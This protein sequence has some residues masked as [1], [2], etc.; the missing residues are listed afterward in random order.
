[1]S[2]ENFASLIGEHG[3]ND[4]VKKYRIGPS[5]MSCDEKNESDTTLP[6]HPTKSS[7]HQPNVWPTANSTLGHTWTTDEGSVRCIKDQNTTPFFA[8][9]HK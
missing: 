8:N 2:T 1:M 3:P 6:Q 9:L 7:L 5:M 4:L